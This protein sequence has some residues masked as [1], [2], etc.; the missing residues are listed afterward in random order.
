MV[1]DLRFRLSAMLLTAAVLAAAVAAAPD[2][3]KGP[4][5]FLRGLCYT[6][7]IAATR[8]AKEEVAWLKRNGINFVAIDFFLI[9]HNYA[10]TDF[11]KI[12]RLVKRLKKEGITVLADYRPST[13]PPGKAHRGPGPDL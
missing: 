7:H 11:P 1:A 5:T 2:R 13:T 9:A 12:A 10:S 6:S 3:R 4:G 8:P